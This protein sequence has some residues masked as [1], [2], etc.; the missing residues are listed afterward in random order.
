[1]SSD[2]EECLL[3][4]V[5]VT[6]G[7]RCLFAT[8]HIIVNNGDDTF[9]DVVQS[10]FEEHALALVGGE[11]VD[12]DE[13][14]DNDG[15]DPIK[16]KAGEM[17]SRIK[18]IKCRKSNMDIELIK[19]LQEH[20]NIKIKSLNSNQTPLFKN[21]IHIQLAPVEDKK[22]PA[23]T[24]L[25]KL[26]I[27]YLHEGI[28]NSES[29]NSKPK[30]RT[31]KRCTSEGCT[32]FALKEGVCARHGAVLK[33][34]SHE[35]CTNRA[36][37]GG[38]CCRHGANVNLRKCSVEGCTY[39]AKRGGLCSRHGERCSH[40]G[41]NYVVTRGGTCDRH[42]NNLTKAPTCKHEGCTSRA[43]KGGVCIKHGATQ[44]R[45]VCTHEGCK[46]RTK[47]DGQCAKHSS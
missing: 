29:A 28:E 41:C 19:F 1:M 15:D 5:N 37:K 42:G 22:R 2:D 25:E 35:G 8:K 9:V 32:N 44:T 36:Q 10:V 3:I 7:G 45:Y 11:N 31:R 13:E 6:E 43:K 17:L 30:K 39:F 34:C 38:L 46:T 47:K 33:R 18:S 21:G 14:F 16:V 20:C 24:E 12:S 4:D 40:E 26:N 23:D 27:E